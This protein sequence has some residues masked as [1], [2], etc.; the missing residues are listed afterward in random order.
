MVYY[1]H[2]ANKCSYFE[3]RY[4]FTK[5][6]HAG[7][8]K[9]TKRK[10]EGAVKFCIVCGK[11]IPESSNRHKIC[12]ERCRLKRRYLA[13]RGQAAPYEYATEPPIAAYSLGELQR[14]AREAGLSYG[15]Y[16]SKLHAGGLSLHGRSAT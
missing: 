2:K 9:V 14:R 11:K 4:T 8:M 7:G 12:G 6:K 13:R 15:Q 1:T 5:D 3:A 16:M 10:N